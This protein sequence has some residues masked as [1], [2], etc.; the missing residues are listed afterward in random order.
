MLDGEMILKILGS[1]IFFVFAIAAT[2]VIE[3]EEPRQ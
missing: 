2:L 3:D 1:I